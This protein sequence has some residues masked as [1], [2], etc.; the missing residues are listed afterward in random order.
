MDDGLREA[1]CSKASRGLPQ[2]RHGGG[3]AR[4]AAVGGSG[5]GLLGPEVCCEGRADRPSAW[6]HVEQR[7]EG[8]AQEGPYGA[9]GSIAAE[10][11][12]LAVPG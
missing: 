3:Q 5:G 12:S 8:R 2:V 11:G 10:Q 9:N 7:L 6:I 1:R 4:A